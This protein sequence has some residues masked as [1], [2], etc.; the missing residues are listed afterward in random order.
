VDAGAIVRALATSPRAQLLDA[1]TS[2][3]HPELVGEV[4]EVVAQ[5]KQQG[6]TMVIATYE[7]AFARGSPTRSASCT[8]AGSSNGACRPTSSTGRNS[9]RDGAPSAASSAPSACDAGAA[10]R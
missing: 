2:A 5:L 10:R 1:I 3:L 8:P 4:L 9:Q 6:T 7:M